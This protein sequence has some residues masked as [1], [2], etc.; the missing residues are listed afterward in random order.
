MIN[1]IFHVRDWNIDF[2]KEL[3]KIILE[4]NSTATFR[5]LVM[6]KSAYKE[7][8]DSQSQV[9]YLPNLL[10][11]A[12]LNEDSVLM[13]FDTYLFNEYGY[14]IQYL[15]ETERFKPKNINSEEFI[16]AH[17]NVLF[18]I[19]PSGSTT[20]ALSCD[21]FVYILSSYITRFKGGESYFIQPSGFPMNAQVIMKSPWDLFPFREM[22]LDSEAL[23]EY[24]ES[25][26]LDPMQS[27]HYMKP[28]K[29]VSLTT[30]ILIRLKTIIH[31]RQQN[32]EYTYLDSL[33]AN[34]IPGRFTQR[35]NINYKF[36]YYNF[37]EFKAESMREKIFYFPLQFEPEM[38]ILAYSPW[39]KNQLEI[40]R[41]VSQS[42]KI[43]DILLLKENPKMIGKR[44]A[45]FY[46]QV[47][48]Y[49]NVVW[50]HPEKNSR[51]IIK[52][53]F[54]VLSVT[55]T[56]TIEAAC[57]GINS[58]LFGY[59]PFKTLIIEKPV[60]DQ[61]LSNMVEILYRYKEPEEIIRHVEENWPEF[62]KSLF[63]GDFIPKY[64][65]NKFTLE[66]SK[67]LA[68]TF[69]SMCLPLLKNNK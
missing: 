18:D 46:K 28:Q 33:P 3:K 32:S 49:N 38:S 45:S 51:E 7:L 53:S 52:K 60:A 12:K 11:K 44:D 48:M 57:L 56:A 61:P 34:I 13:D 41:L 63:F 4:E 66:N 16:K 9:F 64:I 69:S 15:Y 55:G 8:K 14:S 17:F 29:M 67:E 37:D 20:I 23:N 26:N 40:I 27:I 65:E 19:I 25:L 54:K 39:Y 36:N 42:L 22:P 47:S 43:G 1:V 10:D 5:W 21:H 62:S 58:V 68:I 50:A 31:H 2:Y 24:I 59:P 35:K 30:S 6:T